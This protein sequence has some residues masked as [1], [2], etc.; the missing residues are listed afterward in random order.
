MFRV[1]SYTIHVV[2][3]TIEFNNSLNLGLKEFSLESAETDLYSV[4]QRKSEFTTKG[5][6]LF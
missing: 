1:E 3:N 2:K 5:N 4:G 6:Y